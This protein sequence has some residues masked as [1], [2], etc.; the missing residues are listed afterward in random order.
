MPEILLTGSLGVLIT[1]PS[2]Y[3]TSCLEAHEGSG[4]EARASGLGV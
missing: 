2:S 4:A 3:T 1:E